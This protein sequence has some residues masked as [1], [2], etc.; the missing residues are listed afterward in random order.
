MNLVIRASIWFLVSRAFKVKGKAA[1]DDLVAKA[2]ANAD[3]KFLTNLKGQDLVNM[4]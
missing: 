2:V 3:P 1:A 4:P